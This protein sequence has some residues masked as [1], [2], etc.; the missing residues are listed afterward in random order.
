MKMNHLKL[1][2]VDMDGTLLVNRE[3]TSEENVN[4]LLNLQEK[5]VKLTVATGRGVQGLGFIIEALK[6]EQFGGYCVGNNGQELFDIRNDK[7]TIGAKIP[8]EIAYQIIRFGIEQNVRVFGYG[9]GKEMLHIPVGEKVEGLWA[10]RRPYN[11][12][13]FVSERYDMDKVGFSVLEGK[14]LY[15]AEALK[16]VVKD[17]VQVLAVDHRTV[18]I[19]PN[20]VDKVVGV[21]TIVEKYG[22]LPEEVLIFGDGQ[23]DVRMMSKYPS[24]AMGNAYPEIKEVSEYE[25]LTNKESGV[26]YFINHYV[27]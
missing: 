21:D 5:G 14:A 6:L 15:Y 2:V 18:E 23:N 8:F 24:V 26:A 12:E 17:K 27:L 13:E 1:V 4:A 7:L 11:E 16:K 9:G 10:K 25:T 19:V 3:N 22:F 20:G